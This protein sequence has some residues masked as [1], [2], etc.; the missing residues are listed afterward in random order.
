M[1]YVSIYSKFTAETIKKKYFYG[2]LLIVK[3]HF[4]IWALSLH[5]K[6]LIFTFENSV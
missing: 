5:R 1:V 3:P 6:V 2:F 4:I